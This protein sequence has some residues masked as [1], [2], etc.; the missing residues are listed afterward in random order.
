MSSAAPYTLRSHRPGDIGWIIHRQGILYFEEYGWDEHFEA[1]VAEICARFIQNE[2][3][4]CERCWVAERN[5]EIVGAVFC[6]A[7]SDPSRS[8]VSSMSSPRRAGSASALAWSM[9]A[10]TSRGPPAMA[11]SCYGPTTCST[12]RAESTRRRDS[13]CLRKRSTTALGTISFRRRGS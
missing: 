11:R 9:S 12:P 1:L 7:K 2:N 5:G 3:P 6:V 8:C 10:S 4:E 13:G